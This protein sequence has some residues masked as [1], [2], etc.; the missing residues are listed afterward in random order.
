L[1]RAPKLQDETSSHALHRLQEEKQPSVSTK[2]V[3]VHV[4][5]NHVR[6]TT[7]LFVLFRN[8]IAEECDDAAFCSRSCVWGVTA[9]SI[10][11]AIRNGARRC[12]T[13]LDTGAPT[14]ARSHI[15]L[16]SH[17]VSNEWLSLSAT[18]RTRPSRPASTRCPPIA[19]A[20]STRRRVR[21]Q[22][23]ACRRSSFSLPLRA[24]FLILLSFRRSPPGLNGVLPL[25]AALLSDPLGLPP[26]ASIFFLIPFLGCPC[27]FSLPGPVWSSTASRGSIRLDPESAAPAALHL[28]SPGFPPAALLFATVSPPARFGVQPLFSLS[29]SAAVL[30]SHQPLWLGSGP[31]LPPTVFPALPIAKLR[32]PLHLLLP[33]PLLLLRPSPLLLLLPSPL[34]LL[35]PSPI[36]LLPPSTLLL[37]PPSPL[38]LL[39]PSPLLH[40]LLPSPL[41]LLLPS[42]L[43]LLLPSPL[44]LLLPS[45]LLHP[46]LPSTLLP[47]LPS[48]LLLLPPSPLHLLLP[49]PIILLLPSTLLL[50]F[51]HLFSASSFRHLSSSSNRR[52]PS[53]SLRHLTSSSFR[54]LFTSSSFSTSPP[55]PSLSS[56]SISL[57]LS[58]SLSI[59]LDLDLSISRS[60]DPRAR[61]WRSL[62]AALPPSP[63]RSLPAAPPLLSRPHGPPL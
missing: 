21:D 28:A 60:L 1:E 40:L 13:P 20:S 46:L 33:S 23:S 10:L 4:S 25:P 2:Q 48:T 41:H 61:V 6:Q 42:P 27:T 63:P 56:L 45:P 31:K 24:E 5:T 18:G 16:S 62:P 22:A 39:L 54:H 44:H 9:R 15:P 26:A 51:R 57:D 12:R 55:P 52:L 29:V 49:S 50:S 43:L 3:H 59:S 36:I 53:S 14:K 8:A 7:K 38:L 37:L 19:D 35:L 17:F 11:Y 30:E 47:L 58:R 34:H 32:Q